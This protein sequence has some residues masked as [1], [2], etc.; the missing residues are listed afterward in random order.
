MIMKS[1]E[2]SMPVR[3]NALGWIVTLFEGPFSLDW[4]VYLLPEMK[5]THIIAWLEDGVSS[6]HFTKGDI[7]FYRLDNAGARRALQEGLDKDEEHRLRRR[8]AA[9]LLAQDQEGR[10]R[11]ELAYQLLRVDNDL[12]GCRKLT[13]SADHALKSFRNED[14]LQYFAKILDD[15]QKLEGRDEDILFVETAIKYSKISTGRLQTRQII[16]ILGAA[17]KRAVRWVQTGLHALVEMHI[18]KNEWV[19]SGYDESLKHFQKGWALAEA[20]NDPKLKRSAITFS[21]FFH[22]WQ[23]KFSDTVNIYEESAP[24]ITTIPL[25]GFPLL[26]LFT[27][28]YCSAITGQVSHGLGMLD[29]IRTQ[30]KQNAQLHP[31]SYAEGIMGII[32]LNIGRT[33]DAV[34][35]LESSV[36]IASVVHNDWG[37]ISG[38]LV[39]A[40][41]SYRKG[42]SA[43][44][45]RYLQEAMS[46][47]YKANTTVFLDYPYF[48]K[49]AY[50]VEIGDLPAVEG[51]DLENR[52]ERLI[53]GINIFMK[54]ICLRYKALLALG[55][56]ASLPDATDMMKSSIAAL[57]ESG[58]CFEIAESRFELARLFL[59]QGMDSAARALVV[60][61]ADIINPELIPKNLRTLVPSDLFSREVLN[62]VLRFSEQLI[63]IRDHKV[64]LQH[65][66]STAMQI[67]GAE[68][69]GIF[70]LDAAT[71]PPALTLRA[72]KNLTAEQ[73]AHNDFSSSLQII[74][75]VAKKSTPHIMSSTG[76]KTSGGDIV[77]SRICV[78]LVLKGRT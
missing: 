6:G 62:D 30:C 60:S 2:T 71:T 46:L 50:A 56:G 20:I 65:I 3:N 35:M 12:E 38:K 42:S 69:G 45:V 23:G 49:L 26:T 31:L 36:K 43:K 70:F 33:E 32:L 68:R 7:G 54:G 13:E 37:W 63:T 74:R 24:E 17:Q 78:P 18:A 61:T 64:L 75:E 25:K 76:V 4:L 40:Y 15:L 9:V 77:R 16:D 34:R 58:H 73:V 53:G 44:A 72:S 59:M 27:V 10:K 21:T 41:I 51:L 67:T 39:L 14:A 47:T 1:R 55:R 57:E 48:I 28:G 29:A 11:D 5:P 22:F 52:M 19:G 8:I 66:L